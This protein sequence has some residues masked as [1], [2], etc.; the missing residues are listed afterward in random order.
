MRHIGT[1]TIGR[2]RGLR[3]T[4]FDDLG[5]INLLAGE[6]NAGKTSVLEA[7]FLYASPLDERRWR[8]VAHAREGLTERGSSVAASHLV[9]CLP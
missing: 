5:Q 2:F 3:G 1:F 7:F 6:N 9:D 4:Q 8:Q